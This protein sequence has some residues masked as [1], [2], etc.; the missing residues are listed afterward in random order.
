MEKQR[1]SGFL[2]IHSARNKRAR[3]L[4]RPDSRIHILF[5][6]YRTVCRGVKSQVGCLVKVCV[7]VCVRV[8]W[9]AGGE[10][11]QEDVAELDWHICT[12]SLRILTGRGVKG[13][14]RDKSVPTVRKDKKLVRD[15]WW[16]EPWEALGGKW[17]LEKQDQPQAKRELPRA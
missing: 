5:P 8:V 16:S 11:S 13:Q 6:T 14:K 15:T 10:E 12:Q 4:P 1:G 2:F 17:L 9:G 7:S 3:C